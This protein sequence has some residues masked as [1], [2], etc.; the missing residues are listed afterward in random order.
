MLLKR[1]DWVLDYQKF[2]SFELVFTTNIELLSHLG[3]YLEAENLLDDYERSVPNRDVR[4]IHY[5]AMRCQYHW[6]KDD[7]A[8]A[9]QWG[10]KGKKLV[11]SGVETQYYILHRLALAE[12]DSGHPEVAVQTFLNG[13]SLSKVID[14]A[15][16]DQDLNRHY[17]GTT[18]VRLK[19]RKAILTH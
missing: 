16:L 1:V 6:T 8:T 11:D 10:R 4:Y 15:I 19:S 9:V 13:R 14:P 12:R 3:E 17:Y 7:F 18:T 2:K 5:C